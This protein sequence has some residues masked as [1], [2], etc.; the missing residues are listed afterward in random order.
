MKNLLSGTQ[1][2]R[3]DRGQYAEYVEIREFGMALFRDCRSIEHHC[4]QA[5]AISSS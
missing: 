5:F 4:H 1:F 2:P 3:R